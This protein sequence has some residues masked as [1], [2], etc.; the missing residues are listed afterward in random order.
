MP[1]GES[2]GIPTQRI[3]RGM[4]RASQGEKS[5]HSN[6]IEFTTD[7]LTTDRHHHTADSRQS[8]RHWDARW[9]SVW[10]LAWSLPRHQNHRLSEGVTAVLARNKQFLPFTERATTA[11]RRS[12]SLREAPT[13]LLHGRTVAEGVSSHRSQHHQ[14]RALETHGEGRGTPA[15]PAPADPPQRVSRGE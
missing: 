6:G 14:L 13:T 10:P 12:T 3:T 7:T 4:A 9:P 8:L 15:Q 11:A 1:E 5:S 2:A